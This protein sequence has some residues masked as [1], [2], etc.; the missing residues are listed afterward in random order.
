MDAA[1][2]PP[3]PAWDWFARQRLLWREARRRLA[4]GGHPSAARFRAADT[5]AD[6]VALLR[7]EFP[8]DA[9]VRSVVADVVAELAFLGRT[10]VPFARLGVRTPPRGMRW[11]W[12]TLTGERLDGAGAPAVSDTSARQLTLDEVHEG[13]GG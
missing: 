3:A 7:A 10:D 13:L 2:R 6:V 5:R 12:T 9:T 1:F 4:T 11:W 8:R